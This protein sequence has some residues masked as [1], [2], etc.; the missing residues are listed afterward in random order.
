MQN[1]LNKFLVIG[2]VLVG[3]IIGGALSRP[4]GAQGQGQGQGGGGVTIAGPLPLPITGTVN[5]VQGGAWTVG[6]NGTPTVNANV[7]N[8]LTGTVSVS[9]LPS[10][11]LTLPSQPFMDEIDLNVA[12]V[13]KAVGVSGQRLAVTTLTI[14]N[15]DTFPQQLFIVNPVMDSSGCGGSVVGGAFPL[16]HVLLEPSK[17]VQLQYPTPMAFS[18]S[19]QGCIAAEVTTVL[20]GGSVVV[21]VV[22][23]SAP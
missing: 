4:A 19:G 2:A 9:S 11:R 6:I 15:F 21:G 7:T 10:V 14:S 22:G 1:R 8:A 5:A 23:F 13:A 12:G 16:A 3:G 18:L 20:H 17:T